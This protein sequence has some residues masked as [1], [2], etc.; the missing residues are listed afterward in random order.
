MQPW[1]AQI[2][3]GLDDGSWDKF[4][5][6]AYLL[7]FIVIP[8]VNVIKDKAVKRAE[9]KRAAEA[10]RR[11]IQAGKETGLPRVEPKHQA[12]RPLHAQRLGQPGR[13]TP[14]IRPASSAQGPKVSLPVR[15]GTESTA[16]HAEGPQPPAPPPP[17][18]TPIRIRRLPGERAEPKTPRM[19]PA[20]ARPAPAPMARAA[21]KPATPKQK[22]AAPKRKPE[23]RPVKELDV[24][25]AAPQVN[26]HAA[27]PAVRVSSAR[28]LVDVHASDP[29]VDLKRL[30]DTAAP[31]LVEVGS[32]SMT[33]EQM[34]RAVIL[35]ELLRPPV[36]LRNAPTAGGL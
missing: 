8:I 23:P 10:A 21:P 19:R 20:P 24:G 11:K 33:A 36:A 31:G 16:P 6:L 1:L 25:Q 18:P 5:P 12:A 34:R 22:K 35:S 7:I 15:P 13:A 4:K 32:D 17:P 26:V 30:R 2:A 28:P 27:D 3:Q 9:E 14:P 29:K